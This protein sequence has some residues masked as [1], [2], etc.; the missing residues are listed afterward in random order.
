MIL[1]EAPAP[2]AEPVA[3]RAGRGPRRPSPSR[4]RSPSPLSAKAEPALAEAAER[5][6]AHLHENPELDPTDVAYSLATTRSAFEH[7][8]VVLG[9]DRE[10]LL[11]SLTALA[12]GDPSPTSSA[13]AP[14]TASSPTCSPARAPSASAWARSSMSQT[15]TSKRLRRVCEQL[16]PHLETPL[17]EI[18]FAKGKKAAALLEDTTYAQ[19][20]LFA[21]EVALYEAL[22]KRGLTPDLLA[23][24]SIGEIAAAHVA[25]VFDLPDAA[26][27][28][29]ARGRL[30]G[31]LPKGGAMAA[32]EAT[33]EEIAESIAGKEAR[34]V[35]RRDQRPDLD[36]HLRRRGGGRS[37]PHPL[38]GARAERPSASPSPTPST[39]R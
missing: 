29:A 34:A 8:A 36:R 37:G 17:K 33:E 16:D 27:L 2:G 10:E 1:E 3:E 5:L 6:A 12:N 9:T 31:A 19:P 11:A 25:G 18:V 22:A 14:R 4:A 13:P 24:H 35:D 23:G 21:I 20:A 38:G 7:R 26:K 32:I 39:R 30:M 28:V 15:R